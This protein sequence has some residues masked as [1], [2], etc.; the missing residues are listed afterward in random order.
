VK[1]SRRM[2][3]LLLSITA[4]ACRDS[5][6]SSSERS[7]ISSDCESLAGA[8]AEGFDGTV[9]DTWPTTDSRL[10]E[11]RDRFRRAFA[12]M[13]AEG[14]RC[15]RALIAAERSD[16]AFLAVAA[17]ML[18]KSDLSKASLE[19][20]RDALGRIDL[21][22]VSRVE[23][24]DDAVTLAQHEVDTGSLGAKYLTCRE[25]DQD[26]STD[27]T[28]KSVKLSRDY[29]GIC[30]FGSMPS[31]LA[32]QWLVRLLPSVEPFARDATALATCMQATPA[33]LRALREFATKDQLSPGVR[34]TVEECLTR[35]T[36]VTSR[37]DD[38]RRDEYVAALERAIRVGYCIEADESF[39]A[40]AMRSLRANDVDLV[41]E[42]RRRVMT[43]GRGHTIDAYLVLTRLLYGLINRFGLYADARLG[44]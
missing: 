21:S 4:G 31:D 42:A 23:F 24:I 14:P 27:N 39:A 28:Q 30:L 29:G 36:D 11:G 1:T 13:G 43:N 6:P 19:S 18:L 20:A 41:R 17:D 37:P 12:A 8:K 25:V 9:S 10:N 33:C 44:G 5:Q 34:N 22:K 40:D 26:A 35:A 15:L 16:S 38:A 32:D 2:A 7:P 3:A